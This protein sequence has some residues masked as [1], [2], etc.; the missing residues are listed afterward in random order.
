MKSHVTAG[1]FLL[2]CA[3]LAQGWREN[4]QELKTSSKPESGKWLISDNLRMTQNS[5]SFEIVGLKG[6]PLVA[7]SIP[8]DFTGP[9]RYLQIRV[10]ACSRLVTMGTNIGPLLGWI[11]YQPGLYTVP[12]YETARPDLNKKPL[13]GSMNFSLRIMSGKFQF[14][15]LA[16]VDDHATDGVFITVS[17]PDGKVKDSRSAAVAGDTMTIEMQVKD[18]PDNLSL[19]LYQINDGNN[20]VY[21]GRF[22]AVTLPGVPIDLKAT[23]IPNRYRAS[24]K[25]QKTANGLKI[26]GGKLV[27]A[28]NYLGA[29]SNNRGYYYGFC[30]NPVELEER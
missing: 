5:N 16:M 15:E 14:G 30:A 2:S 9:V 6:T 18:K 10:L 23:E 25:L 4:F 1:I 20:W 22:E 24:F 13:K 8:Y 28:I 3:L 26:K 7:R 12:V 21:R 17:G 29:D 11:H 27:A 19:Y